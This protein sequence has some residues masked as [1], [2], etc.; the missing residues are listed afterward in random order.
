MSKQDVNN[1]EVAGATTV[2]PFKEKDYVSV[3]LSDNTFFK[4]TITSIFNENGLDRYAIT[5]KKLGQTIDLDVNDKSIKP[6]FYANK[7]GNR[8]NLRFDERE[9]AALIKKLKSVEANT[10]RK[11]E[12]AN[13]TLKDFTSQKTKTQLLQ[14]KRTNVMKGIVWEKERE[15]E[16]GDS[17]TKKMNKEGRFQL[18]YDKE[19]NYRLSVRFEP[20]FLKLTIP[21]KIFETELTDKQK[22]VLETKGNLGLVKGITSVNKSTGEIK[23]FDAYVSVDKELNSVSVRNS[24]TINLEEI[25]GTKLNAVQKRSLEAGLGII[26]DVKLKS[27]NKALY[28]EANAASVSPDGMIKM[29]KEK[30]IEKGLYKE[31]EKKAEKKNDKSKSKGV[32]I[33]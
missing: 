9:V 23:E 24:S 10:G 11:S 8:V 3:K 30:A 29:D 18:F 21:N 32:E 1:V 16:N 17:S 7:K 33:G 22:E 26:V 15:L 13:L 14:G 19:N 6:L 25:Y 20:K 4:G 31:S 5:N 12:F 27:G 2:T 28:V